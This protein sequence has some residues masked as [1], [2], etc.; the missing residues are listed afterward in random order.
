MLESVHATSTENELHARVPVDVFVDIVAAACSACCAA[1][2]N[3]KVCAAHDL[4]MSQLDASS[5]PMLRSL[6]K[7]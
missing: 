5:T 2:H 7:K 6:L 3:Q 1:G 4:I